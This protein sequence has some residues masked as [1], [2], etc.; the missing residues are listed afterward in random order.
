MGPLVGS[1]RRREVMSET[2]ARRNPFVTGLTFA[3]MIASVSIPCRNKDY[4]VD[5]GVV[6]DSRYISLQSFFAG[7]AQ[8]QATR[9]TP[10]SPKK[11]PKVSSSIKDQLTLIFRE[12][13]RWSSFVV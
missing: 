5:V 6:S 7:A 10:M 1:R 4:N 8:E 3:G 13:I 11:G 12:T 2:E 9:Q